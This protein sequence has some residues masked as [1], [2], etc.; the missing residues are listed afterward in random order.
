MKSIKNLTLEDIVE[1]LKES[2]EKEII[3][4]IKD[5]KTDSNDLDK[6]DD[7]VKQILFHDRI[8]LNLSILDILSGREK[9]SKISR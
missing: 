4:L 2:W 7:A 6:I 8:E 3:Y 1:I 9:T 5:P